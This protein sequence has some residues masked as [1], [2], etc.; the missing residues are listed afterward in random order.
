[1]EGP[2]RGTRAG[3]LGP[4]WL[5]IDLVRPVAFL[6]A[7]V[8]VDR[9]LGPWWAAPLA[10]GAVLSSSVLVHDAIHGSLGLPARANDLVLA[11]YALFLVKSGHALRRLHLEH[12]ARCL[13]DDDREGNV[14][15]IS[16]TRLLLTGPWLALEAR[17]LSWS[18]ETRPR[19]RWWQAIETA[20]DVAIVAALA[21]ATWRTGELGPIVYLGTVI[22]VTVTV[23]IL[24]AKVPHL[25]PERWPRLVRALRPWTTRLTPA[26]SSLLFHELH[27]RRPRIPAVLLA[28]NA[29]LLDTT[30]PS[31]CA[32]RLDAVEGRG[33]G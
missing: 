28:E 18:A 2:R 12:H 10:L 33:R 6:V 22:A 21:G 17:V 5:T 23:P 25:L 7:F 19:G 8:A 15:F 27:H 11:V 16:T 3:G 1:M 9:L 4:V 29:P 20:A 24:G 30:D 13:E 31:T 14:V 32:E 26:A